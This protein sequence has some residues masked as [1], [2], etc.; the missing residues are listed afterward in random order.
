MTGDGE[1]VHPG[2]V[3]KRSGSVPTLRDDQDRNSSIEVL[4][5]S[6]AA[7]TVLAVPTQTEP[8]VGMTEAPKMSL[9]GKRQSR[10]HAADSEH[11]S[12]SGANVKKVKL[13][14][15][16]ARQAVA[17]N[18]L[19]KDKSRL[20]A[21]VWHHIFS[22]CPPR[23][24]GNLLRVNKLFNH[25]LD[26]SSS[27]VNREVPLPTAKGVLGFLKPNVIWQLS[28]RL[29]WPQ[30][31][32]PLR[33]MAE[34]DM[35]RLAC[36]LKCQNCN[37]QPAQSHA[38]LSETCSTAA[39]PCLGPG[40]NGVAVIW[41]FASR[42]CGRCLVMTSTKEID[43]MVTQST[44]SAVLQGIAFA[45]VT[46]DL[47]I[48]P[49]NTPDT[50]KLKL[51]SA[52]DVAEV[53][54]E[55]H[56]VQALGPGAMDEWMKGLNNRGKNMQNQALRWEKWY[57]SG[58]VTR[59]RT[60]LYP[61]YVNIKVS[62]IPNSNS[63][64]PAA[65]PTS[66][67]IALPATRAQVPSSQASSQPRQERTAE[68]VAELK[69]I[70][71][72]EIERRALLLDPPLTPDV[73]RHLPAFEA[74]MQI[75]LPFQDK[76]WDFL[77][78]RL[79]TQR[80]EAEHRHPG[81]LVVKEEAQQNRTE[82]RQLE[83]T[84]ATTKEARE[85][86]DKQWE[87]TQAPLRVRIAGL[88]DEA[89]R[90]TW[91]KGKKV[92]RDN[93]AKFAVDVLCY[94]RKRFYAEVAEKA[95]AAHSVGREVPV[96]PPE[97]PFTQKL[98]LENM[99][100]IFDTKIKPHTE[101]YRKELF[102]C[103]GCDS[104]AKT[105]GF[106]GVIQHYA[107]KHTTA[108]SLGTIVV[109]WRAEW[110][111]YPPF[112]YEHQLSK[113]L[114]HNH[115]FRPS[116]VGSLGVPVLPQ[117]HDYPSTNGHAGLPSF[118]TYPAP[119]YHTALY[120]EQYQAI[121][122]PVYPQGHYNPAPQQPL[123]GQPPLP[124]PQ[125]Q[126]Q[127]QQPY[128]AQ[129]PLYPPYQHPATTYPPLATSEP[130]QGYGPPPP[131]VQA[132]NY[133]SFQANAHSSYPEIQPPGY[134]DGYQIRLE[135]VARSSRETWNS[136]GVIRDLPGSIRVFV[137]IH[138]LVKRFHAM[139]GEVPP[140]SMFIDGLSNNKDMRP[141]RNVNGLVCKACHLKLGNAPHVVEERKAFSLPQLVNHFQSKHIEPMQAQG[142]YPLLDWI[143]DMVLLPN[144]ETL[145]KLRTCG[146]P[147][148][149]MLADALPYLFQ[150]RLT[151]A[152]QYPSP[153]PVLSKGRHF[154]FSGLELN[155][156]AGREQ[157][158]NG[159]PAPRQHLSAGH[160]SGRDSGNMVLPTLTNGRS[161]APQIGYVSEQQPS[162]NLSVPDTSDFGRDVQDEGT[163]A[164]ARNLLDDSS[165]MDNQD[166]HVNLH[167]A[168]ESARLS[169]EEAK[170]VEAGTEERNKG[171]N[172]SRTE[173]GKS[174]SSYHNSGAGEHANRPRE[175]SLVFHPATHTPPRPSMA[176]SRAMQPL[177]ITG[178]EEMSN[179]QHQGHPSAVDH[180]H[181]NLND[182][183]YTIEHGMAAVS[184]A[185]PP[186]RI[187]DRYDEDSR[188]SR[189]PVYGASYQSVPAGRDRS[190]L[191]Q[192]V[193]PAYLSGAR[194]PPLNDEVE[195][196]RYRSQT[197]V[198]EYVPRRAD[199]EVYGRPPP[200]P[201]YHDQDQIPR[202]EYYRNLVDARS[203]SRQLAPAL[204]ADTY[205]IVQVRD[206]QGEYLI[207][208]PVRRDAAAQSFHD[209]GRR[210][211]RDANPDG[212]ASY[213]DS[214]QPVCTADS[215]E[216]PSAAYTRHGTMVREDTERVARGR[217][218]Y[219]EEYDPRFPGAS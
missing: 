164:E 71:K 170:K 203:H 68:E 61:G 210:A 197:V 90:Q 74:A 159:S 219:Y 4:D 59:M 44:P 163:M 24:L 29:F 168:M 172:T 218:P 204:P 160:P 181:R 146:E 75:V 178:H 54:K 196:S 85:L 119:G 6:S 140:F 49:S 79:L 187:Y 201:E 199:T 32:A 207:R 184:G 33:S 138:H 179:L 45:Y 16:R 8:D 131:A 77:K 86:I 18:K 25:Y 165:D 65:S 214:E 43:F 174:Y 14:Q 76:D 10:E 189:S 116:F 191:M 84:L 186:S 144:L 31:P 149:G 120:P 161:D 89:I 21:E 42:L 110:P 37:K 171:W 195:Y 217:D 35:W 139:F 180:R 83:A 82:R 66:Y 206:E 129:P 177:S 152:Q 55:F 78:P 17:L 209:A 216:A 102:Y 20:S 27:L 39:A 123:Y 81:L 107:A 202:P 57:M 34:I 142:V 176:V 162:L 182:R 80:G 198:S 67:P 151:S 156:L 9:L 19:P 106:E 7:S 188:R 194:V 104:N 126:Q 213:A 150:P 69:A 2:P 5:S 169:F 40:L 105:F 205:E 148:R 93:C 137:T 26:P 173:S 62:S 115:G 46:P 30:M 193:A 51:F 136:L 15:D 3:P 73:L 158:Y 56:D 155:G 108:L 87:E 134:P 100:W 101:S 103:N 72:A 92:T 118:Q 97:G 166:R 41:P 208:R 145:S 28:R 58:G 96:D 113:Q 147:Q 47:R 60:E 64:T 215:R 135:I 99:K 52:T 70:R 192:Q 98:T 125:Q 1:D 121:L 117:G 183:S 127:Q 95:A 50:D 114:P 122:P 124:P 154:E 212:A 88:A 91:G 190:L 175:A 111:Q 133:N 153:Y 11:S 211:H 109:H 200:R 53:D 141:V 157:P 94:I 185:A 22:F 63:A 38:A 132:Y 130:P 128:I 13:A 112:R 48:Q 167:P 12:E 143:M 36:S 23:S